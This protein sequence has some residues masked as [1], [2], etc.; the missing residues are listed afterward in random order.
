M[1]YQNLF[2]RVKEPEA[3]RA[4]IIG[5][6]SFGAAIVTQASLVPRLK[7][8]IVADV[9]VESGRLAFLQA[10][11]KKENIAVCDNRASAIRAMETGKAVVVQDSMILMELPLDVIAT[12]TRVAEAGALY[13]YEAIQHGKHVVMVDKEADSV[14]G[15][16]LKHLADKAGVVFTTDDGDQPGLLMGLVSWARSI[17]LEV[18]CGGNMHDCLYNPLELTVRQGSTVVK[19]REEDKWAFEPI[20]NGKAQLYYNA[21]RQ[22]LA[23]LLQD[24]DDGDTICHIVVSANG[25][26]LLPDTPIGHRPVAR[27]TEIPE[28]LCPVEEGGI[29]QTRGAVD[30]P[31]ILR[32]RDEP[33]GG[34]GVFVVVAND[35]AHS[36][37]IM[38]QKG[39]LANSRKSAMLIYRPYHLC[40]AETAM[41][42]LCAGL[43]K[44]PTGSSTLVPRVDMVAKSARDFRAGEIL[45]EKPGSL[46]L[47]LELR[48][49]LMPAVPITGNHPVPFFMLEGKRL[50]RD[51]SSGTVITQDMVIPPQ[52][53]FLWSLRKQQDEYFST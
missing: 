9:N 23:N 11:A 46:G 41:S 3:V 42:I 33:H 7:I 22:I 48:A 51:I 6:G 20:P 53:S 44:V 40:G 35:N 32:T 10:G 28:I 19:L 30:I 37:N 34:G 29:L 38:I 39:L 24:N 12:S 8:P 43:L 31:I 4:G 2:D 13:A 18:L 36:R 17:G 16:I 25:T 49:L 5:C 27:F 52:D 26:S 14:V 1:F 21:R 50:S 47:N 45:G 15:P